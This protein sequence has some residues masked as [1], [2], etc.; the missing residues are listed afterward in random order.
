MKPGDRIATLAMNHSRHL[1]S[2][3]GAIGMGGVLHTINPRLFDEQLE[4]IANH[5]EDRVL[6]YDQAFAPIVERMKPQ[7]DDDRALYLLR[8]T[9]CRRSG[10]ADWIDG[11]TAITLG[12]RRRARSVRPLLHQRHDRQSQGRALRASLDDAAHAMAE[13]IARLLRPV[14]RGGRAADRADVPR[15]CLGHSLGGADDRL[16]A[17]PVG[18]LSPATDVRPVPRREGHPFAPAC[19]PSGSA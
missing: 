6:L 15:Q 10:F 17:G 9:D 11:M 5:A 2:W 7:V 18:R 1:T 4:Y 3:Y 8:S 19:R 13:V 14:A 16:Q 12:R